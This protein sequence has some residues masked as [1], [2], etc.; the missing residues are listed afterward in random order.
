M[1]WR[2]VNKVRKTKVSMCQTIKCVNEV[3][4]KKKVEGS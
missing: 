2:D 4:L 1:F 3:V